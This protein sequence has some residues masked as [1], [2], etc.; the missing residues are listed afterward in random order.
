MK[1]FT[2]ALLSLLAQ[3]TYGQDLLGALEDY[4]NELNKSSNSQVA[5]DNGKV[6]VNEKTETSGKCEDSEQHSL[7]LAYITG[8]IL[9]KDGKLKIGHDARSGQLTVKS[10]KMIS[11][12]SSMIEWV[13]ES[14]VVDR[15]KTYW[16]EAKIKESKK[17]EGGKCE[18]SVAQVE[19]KSFKG[20]KPMSFEPTMKGFEQCLKDSGVI[21]ED[22]KVNPKAIYPATIDEKFGQYN[23]SGDL[24][25]LS[26][27]GA[28]T[29][30]G[31]KYG[32][33]VKK[34]GC[35]HFEKILPDGYLVRSL[36]D[37]ESD[38]MA[39]ERAQVEG[40]GDYARISEFIEKYQVYEDNLNDIR[41]KLILEAVKTSAKAITE[42]NY[43]EDD[44]KT[45]ADFEKYII[46]PKIDRAKALYEAAQKAEGEQKKTLLADMNKILEQLKPYNQSPYI[47]AAVVQKLEAYGRFDDA[48]RSNGIK[49]LIVSHARLG[50]TENGVVIT[51]DVAKTR[52]TNLR[53]AY[54]DEL[55][56]K[57]E[58]YQIRTGQVTGYAQTY[59]D[60]ASQM[61][62][63][64][65]VRTRNFSEEIQREYARMRQ[66]GHCYRPYRN[67]Q[68]C[69]QDSQ[70]RI[71]ELQAE[72]QHFNKVDAE[73]A[74]EYEQKAKEYAELEKQGRNYVADQTGE[75]AQQV[76]YNNTSPSPRN[77]EGYQFDFQ[78]YDQQQNQQQNQYQQ[79]NQQ[80]M[81]QQQMYQQPGYNNQFYAGGQ[82]GSNMG[83][84]YGFY[85]QNYNPYQQQQGAY[86]FNYQG[87]Q[88]QPGFFNGQQNPF[89]QQGYQQQQS[90]W[91]S[92]YQAYSQYNMYR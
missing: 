61:R 79:Q 75:P 29:V 48:E 83:N 67:V 53:Q 40:C 88:Q 42:G 44:L 33:F 55:E 90:Y 10:P 72:L 85:N 32:E 87:Y 82:F 71:Q 23:E 64:I 24:L 84:Q 15:K 51:P 18:Y 80:Q 8:L 28:S 20:F 78:G 39:D 6:T 9:E 2:V 1:M 14:K 12:C 37:I 30:P 17:C 13:S 77:D 3:S 63:N 19:A 21:T 92:P 45:I 11:N 43:T 50:A 59:Y 76:T 49:A 47:S 5:N 54:A 74:L 56:V 81:Y 35:K 57:K 70:L 66:G 73:R 27:G 46:Q 52:A 89:Q 86:N 31:A 22:N 91:G 62:Q 38:R 36:Q 25:F 68:R 69:I 7:P 4:Q 41:D 26:N 58:N 65:Q 16:I 34:D 60:L